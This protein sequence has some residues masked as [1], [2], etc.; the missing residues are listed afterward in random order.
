MIVKPRSR[1]G[2][3]RTLENETGPRAGRAK[4]LG[5]VVAVSLRVHLG[6]ASDAGET[7]V[8]CNSGY[9]GLAGLGKVEVLVGT[10]QVDL[11]QVLRRGHV[12]VATESLLE[13]PDAD[14]GASASRWNGGAARGGRRRANDIGNRL[15]PI[16]SRIAPDRRGRSRM[17]CSPARAALV[18]PHRMTY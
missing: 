12:E 2:P 4:R 11:A 18:H 16:M 13:G 17:S 14:A 5:G 15:C 8:V 9:R 3:R 6:E 10:G 7:R 1:R